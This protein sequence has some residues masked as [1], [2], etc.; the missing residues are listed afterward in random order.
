M[1]IFI[2]LMYSWVGL[3]YIL[4]SFQAFNLVSRHFNELL[5]RGPELCAVLEN[6]ICCVEKMPFVSL[7]E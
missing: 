7:A 4:E 1:Y 3:D 5:P 6:K 2:I